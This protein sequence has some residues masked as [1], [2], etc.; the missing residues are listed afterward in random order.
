MAALPITTITRRR[1][2]V[3]GIVQGVGFRP[4]VYGHALQCG[5]VGFVLNDSTGV[6]IEI[7]GQRDALVRFE[8]ALRDQPP[9]LARIDSIM[10][11]DIAPRGDR[12]FVITHS[13]AGDERR[14]L[15]SPD[16]ATCADC[17]RELFDPSDRRYR[18]PFINCTNCGPRFTIVQ[19]VPYDRD[20]T[21]MRVFPMCPAC[22]AEYDNPLDR[23]FHAQPNAC[24]SCGPQVV[25]RTA[26]GDALAAAD[27]ITTAA[28]QLASGMILA[29]K[30][31][32]GYHL[33]CDALNEAA[34]TRLRQRKHREAKPFALLAPNLSTIRQLCEVNEDEA[35]VLT[36][37][38][39][40]IVVL[41]QRCECLI[42]ADV[43]P[44][45]TTLGIM[46]PYT[47][48]HHLLIAAFASAVGPDRPAVLVMTSGNL[49]DEPIAYHDDDAQTRLAP[50]VDGALT[51]DRDIYMRCDDS[52]AR[53]TVAGEQIMRRSRGYA[54]EPIPLSCAS[55]IPL[56]ACGG[57]LKNTF[58]LAKHNQ[59]FVS[60]HIGDLENLE[61]LTSFR[62]GIQ[63]FERLF[64]IQPEAV[65][66][67]LHPE[68]LA[69]KFALE[70]ELPQ[71]LGVQHHHAHIASV[72][73]EHGVMGPVIGVAA[74]GSGY[75]TDGAIWGGEV[76][77]ADLL[78]F[79]RQAHLAYVPLPGGDQ[80][81]RQPWRMAAVYL[82]QAYG[83]A[84]TNLDIPFVRHCD[85]GRWRPLAQMIKHR[86]N[87]P[88]TS[89]LGR[90]FDA[91]AALL[92]IRLAVLYEGQ[93]AIELEMLAEPSTSSYPF[94]C[95][96]GTP[97]TMDVTPLLRAIVA[98]VRQGV[99]IPHIVGRFHRT[100]AD[101]LAEMCCRVRAQTGLHVVALS[102][103]VFQNRL[104]LE[105]LVGQLEEGEFQVLINRRVPANDGGLSLGQVAVAAARLQSR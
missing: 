31:L 40:P 8:L 24:A 51:H 30:G 103:G 101:M 16:T 89:S 81:V 39:R 5:L 46:L 6:T 93:A 98:D 41:R 100:I 97:A 13:V 75:G 68:Y 36:S 76:L 90:L 27:P 58:C 54:P 38:R 84:W 80:A 78:Q 79:E 56:L 44:H 69:T 14:A 43:A 29:I 48:L 88:P 32:G 59:A 62:E 77:V 52:V 63:H 102:G 96:E 34:V 1:I 55:P 99:P 4:F 18:Y 28:Q 26:A 82:Q 42:A 85:L 2:A 15:I 66:Y 86:L 7:E 70:L 20:R 47:P 67:D 35:A 83:D 50:I 95:G 104:L 92:G 74:D 94:A 53:I 49:S 3:Q 45:S 10:A 72:L 61:T 23:R 71:K 91:V 57:Q 73:A 17:L 60:H 9:P 25:L 33:A 21:T 65:A 12:A 105:Q 19:D 11:E 64:G 87:S 37:R 22:Q